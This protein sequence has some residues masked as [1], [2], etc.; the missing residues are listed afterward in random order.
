MA[1][2]PKTVVHVNHSVH[3][4]ESYH[5]RPLDVAPSPGCPR[6]F[7][8]LPPDI[9]LSNFAA[10]QHRRPSRRRWSFTLIGSVIVLLLVFHAQLLR[11]VL[12]PTPKSTIIPLY[13]DDIL[14]KCRF[15]N[16]TPAP[17]PEFA[18]RTVSDRFQP[19]TKPV[20]IRNA[21]IWTGADEGLEVL[22]G[23]VYL[24]GGIIKRIGS[25]DTR[26]S[27]GMFISLMRM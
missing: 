2:C 16:V 19:G 25:F 22:L 8:P 9:Y 27:L 21:T 5:Q 14:D 4:V 24:E 20:L 6:N 17:S 7:K 26:C 15:L 13:S 3:P 23:D 18:T 1:H 11:A 12:R 10:A